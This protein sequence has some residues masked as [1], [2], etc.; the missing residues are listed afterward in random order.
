M[1]V[2]RLLLGSCLGASLMVLGSA[3]ASAGTTM[4]TTGPTTTEGAATW[5]PLAAQPA[6]VHAGEVYDVSGNICP[7]GWTITEIRIHKQGP[8]AEDPNLAE[9]PDPAT[10]DITQTGSG[11][12]YRRT[13]P[14][15]PPDAPHDEWV[16]VACTDGSQ[17]ATGTSTVVTIFPADGGPFW[18]AFYVDGAAAVQVVV[19]S[20]DC[21][22]DSPG[23]ITLASTTGWTGTASSTFRVERAAAGDEVRALFVVPMPRP[24]AAG[25]TITGSVTC[26][27]DGVDTTFTLLHASPSITIAGPDEPLPSTGSGAFVWLA[28]ACGITGLGVLIAMRARPRPLS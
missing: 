15:Y 28:I 23:T 1:S 14:D 27:V 9:L 11:F 20:I 12:S 6:T 7:T 19:T 22:A 8:A 21:D 2:T 10:A 3:R 18:S 25:S 13:V 26:T 4:A 16:D 5:T 17:Q 24:S